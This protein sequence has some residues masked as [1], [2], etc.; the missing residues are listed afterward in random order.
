MWDPASTYVDADVEL[1]EDVSLLPGTI[2]KGVVPDRRGRPDRPERAARRRDRRREGPA[3][4]RSTPRA[5]R[6]GEDAEVGSFSVLG[7]GHRRARRARASARTRRS[8]C[9]RRAPRPTEAS[10][11]RVEVISKHR[12]EF[13]SGRSHPELAAR[14]RPAPRRAAVRAEPPRV[15]QRRDPLPLRGV[16]ARRGRLHP[17]DPL[18]AGERLAH[19]AADHDRRGEARVGEADHRGV[20]LLRLLAPGPQV[21]GPRADHREARRRH[22]ARPPVRT[23]SCRSTCTPDRSRASSTSRSTTSPRHRSSRRTCAS[24]RRRTSSS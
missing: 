12:L 15:R 22:A 19:G 17:P 10:L 4:A 1:A 11:R 24:R 20:P 16:A 6:I 2:V 13:V 5:R 3:R 23:A 14:H 21:H 7:P 9:S 18:R 8:A